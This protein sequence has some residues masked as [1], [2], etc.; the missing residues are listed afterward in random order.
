MIPILIV[1]IVV[2]GTAFR[3][4][5][6]C[7]GKGFFHKGI[8][9]VDLYP[10]RLSADVLA[11]LS[12]AA[13][14][15]GTVAVVADTLIRHIVGIE[16]QIRILGLDCR[17]HIFDVAFHTLIH[18][19]RGNPVS[20]GIEVFLEKPQRCLA[21]P[22]QRMTTHGNV[23]IDAEVHD[24]GSIVQRNTDIRFAALRLHQRCIWLGFVL[25]LDAV[26]VLQHTGS[27]GGVLHS[28][29]IENIAHPK[30]VGKLVFQSLFR[31]RRRNLA[32]VLLSC[33]G[34]IIKHKIVSAVC[35]NGQPEFA[36]VFRCTIRSRKLRPFAGSGLFCRQF[37]F[38]FLCRVQICTG[39]GQVKTL[40]SFT[41]HPH[42]V[43]VGF[44]AGKIE[45]LFCTGTVRRAGSSGNRH[46]TG[47]VVTDA[48]FCC[49]SYSIIVA[50][51]A[52]VVD[53]KVV[54]DQLCRRYCS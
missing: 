39:K 4:I 33:Y 23:I 47:R 41:V 7:I 22:H 12:G 10:R 28:T 11:R 27:N 49:Q 6:P 29:A 40:R 53:F 52:A 1:I 5:F 13:V 18:D 24:A 51:P 14:V 21:M 48:V 30:I 38:R 25:A 50:V 20:A 35:G 42:A 31:S 2:E 9:A 26:I 45:A 32:A 17:K 8:T 44:P 16:I 34:D 46:T 54:A 36:A 43:C 19:C 15:G 37:G 3:C